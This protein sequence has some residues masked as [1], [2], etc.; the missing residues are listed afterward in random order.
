M[1]QAQSGLLGF[2][3]NGYSRFLSATIS[4]NHHPSSVCLSCDFI[5]HEAHSDFVTSKPLIT[6]DAHPL[7]L[8]GT[9]PRGRVACTYVGGGEPDIRS[10]FIFAHAHR[11]E[12]RIYPR[13][14]TSCALRAPRSTL[15]LL[16]TT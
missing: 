13:L 3:V 11:L 1:L 4:G 10:S 15:L 8:C 16:H 7:L 9:D 5:D 6:P 2:L 14:P 12:T